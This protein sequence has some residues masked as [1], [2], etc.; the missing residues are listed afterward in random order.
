MSQVSNEVTF[1][2]GR[3]S[4]RKRT[5]VT[6]CS[7]DDLDMSDAESDYDKVPAKKK[8]NAPVITKRLPRRKIFPFLQLPAEIRNIIYCYALTD[9]GGSKYHYYLH[10][11]NQHHPNHLTTVRFNAVFKHKRRTVARVL[12]RDTALNL[13]VNLPVLVPALLALNKQTNSEARSILYSNDFIFSDTSA[14]YN[15]L[16]NLGPSGAKQLKHLC[17]KKW[18]YSPVMKAYNHSCFSALVWATNLQSLRLQHDSG[19]YRKPTAAAD[20]FYRDAF[21]WL[22]AVGAAQGKVDAGVDLLHIEADLFKTSLWNG[23]THQVVAGDDQLALYRG[24]LRKMLGAQLKRVM[25]TAGKQK[26]VVRDE[27]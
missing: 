4:K 20:Q 2:S 23:R 13:V 7:M 26:K 14:L 22:E 8:R 19:W 18:G 27:L 15:F 16:I 3:Y 24:Q 10:M 12:T 1:A 17:L 25:G 21:P 9:D 11:T 5:A 6:Y